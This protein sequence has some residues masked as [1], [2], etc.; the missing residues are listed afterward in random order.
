MPKSRI[1]RWPLAAAIGTIGVLTGF[2][3]QMESISVSPLYAGQ[4][5]A[6]S[7]ANAAATSRSIGSGGACRSETSAAA[8]ATTVV[9]GKRKT[10]REQTTDR[11]DAC[12]RPASSEAAASVEDGTPADRDAEQ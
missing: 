8:E 3:T 10:M 6:S 4:A 11:S 2:M 5:S 9:N 12:G 1:G 7:S